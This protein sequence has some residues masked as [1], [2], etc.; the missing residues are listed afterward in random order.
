MSNLKWIFHTC[1]AEYGILRLS[2]QSRTK[3][4]KNLGKM[5]TVAKVYQTML[6]LMIKLV[7]VLNKQLTKWNI[8]NLR[9]KASPE[10][11][12]QNRLV[13][14]CLCTCR[15]YLPATKILATKIFLLVNLLDRAQAPKRLEIGKL[16]RVFLHMSSLKLRLRKSCSA[17]EKRK[18]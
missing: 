10:T 17:P 4:L 11:E 3:A 15:R 14:F 8:Q 7:S 1:L 5:E 2:I 12:K 18:L 13:S 9:I 6:L 16:Q